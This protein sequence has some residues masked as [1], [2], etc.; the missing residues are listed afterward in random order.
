[1]NISIGETIIIVLKVGLIVGVPI[2]IVLAGFLLFRRIH[3][4]ES[5][6]EKLEDKQDTPQIRRFDW[7]KI[8]PTRRAPDWWDSAAFSGIFLASNFSCY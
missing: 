2:V 8:Y 5:R 6:I 3:V 4:L 1:M 7:H